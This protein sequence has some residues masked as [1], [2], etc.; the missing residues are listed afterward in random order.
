MAAFNDQAEKFFNMVSG[1]GC[2]WELSLVL[3]SLPGA[4]ISYSWLLMNPCAY[5]N[6]NAAGRS[7]QGYHAVQ[8]C[9]QPQEAG[10][11]EGQ[12]AWGRISNPQVL[13]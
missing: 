6:I 7:R 10:E 1:G 11:R 9:S 13:P 2:V 5:I 4:P 12:R 3:S 8:G